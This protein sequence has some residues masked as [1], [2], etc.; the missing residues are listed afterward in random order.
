M[1]KSRGCV[2]DTQALPDWFFWQPLPTWSHVTCP[3]WKSFMNFWNAVDPSALER[4]VWLMLQQRR[5]TL[6]QSAEES[7]IYFTL[8]QLYFGTVNKFEQAH[9]RLF[10]VIAN[11]S[12]NFPK[13]LMKTT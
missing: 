2:R 1:F 6:A 4:A 13:V 10:A 7:N 3:T 12:S 8:K 9:I 5:P 11:P